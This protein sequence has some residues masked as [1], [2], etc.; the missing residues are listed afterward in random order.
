[1]DEHVFTAAFLLDK[2]EALVRV[3][4]L[5]R[6]LASADD[7]GRHS[8]ATRATKTASTRAAESTALAI[9]AE[10]AAPA[11]KPVAAAEAI[12]ATT[13]KRIEALFT[14]PV[15]LVAAPPAAPSIKTHK[16]AR[17]FVSPLNNRPGSTDESRRTA[18]ESA[19]Y[20]SLRDFGID[21]M[22]FQRE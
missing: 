12:T 21:Q 14:K 5:Y 10:A 16:P 1:M 15:A 17:T 20:A 8:A 9:T 11:A 7:L 2:A 19:Q 22:R 6:S 13:A 18:K 3:E 4:E